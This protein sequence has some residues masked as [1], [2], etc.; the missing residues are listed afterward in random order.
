MAEEIFEQPT[1]L[2]EL[3]RRLASPEDE[4]VSLRD[5]YISSANIRAFST[6]TGGIVDINEE[7]DDSEFMTDTLQRLDDKAN[8]ARVANIHQ[9]FGDEAILPTPPTVQPPAT[10]LE[11]E[12]LPEIGPDERPGFIQSLKENVFSFFSGVGEAELQRQE[13]LQV[14]AEVAVPAVAG[15]VQDVVFEG[16][17]LL[18]D[19]FNALNSALGGS[20]DAFAVGEALDKGTNYLGIQVPPAKT[21][22]Q[23]VIRG[24]TKIGLEI[25]VISATTGGLGTGSASTRL[26]G[27]GKFAQMV[28]RMA[29][30][31]TIGAQV[32]ILQDPEQ[33][34]L[35]TMIEKV[36]Q[37]PEQYPEAIRAF[38]TGFESLPQWTQDFFNNFQFDEDDSNIEKRLKSVGEGAVLGFLVDL[39]VE[40]LRGI[41]TGVRA[42]NSARAISAD[43]TAGL[44]ASRLARAGEDVPVSPALTGEAIG[45]EQL[46]LPFRGEQLE[47]P[48]GQEQLALPLREQPTSVVPTP[49]QIDTGEQLDLV[50]QRQV[51]KELTPEDV[52]LDFV[53]KGD[54]ESFDFNKV[55]KDIAR[56]FT[57][58]PE[59]AR[60]ILG[61]ALNVAEEV[62][63]IVPEIGAKLPPIQEAA[64]DIL[65]EGQA[66]GMGNFNLIRSKYSLARKYNIPVDQAEDL[67]ITTSKDLLDSTEFAAS[68]RTSPATVEDVLLEEAINAGG[69]Q[70]RGADRVAV[71]ERI[72]QLYNLTDREA[73][74]KIVEFNDTLKGLKD[75]K[76][77]LDDVFPKKP[78]EV[79]P[80]AP[81][82]GEQLELPVNAQQRLDLNVRPRDVDTPTAKPE[83]T[84]AIN[85]LADDTVKE[86]VENTPGITKVVSQKVL[87]E[88]I[89]DML[90]GTV[91]GTAV[92]T[93]TAD[94]NPLL[95][96]FTGA[97]IGAGGAVALGR[98]LRPL[99][100]RKATQ[101]R[102]VGLSIQDG[103]SEGAKTSRLKGFAGDPARVD[104]LLGQKIAEGGPSALAYSLVKNYK[105]GSAFEDDHIKAIIGEMHNLSS[106][107]DDSL[108]GLND[109]AKSAASEET[110][111]NLH[112]SILETGGLAERFDSV[113]TQVGSESGKALKSFDD[114]TLRGARG[115][116]RRFKN[117]AT[118]NVDEM[119]AQANE[120]IKPKALEFRKPIRVGLAAL[121]VLENAGLSAIL[122][123]PA[124]RIKD[125]L[126]NTAFVK[127]ASELSSITIGAGA[128]FVKHPLNPI[129][130]TQ[131]GVTLSEAMGAWE[132][133]GRGFYSA[134]WMAVDRLLATSDDL[135][136]LALNRQIAV[137]KEI[138]ATQGAEAAEKAA[139]KI[140]EGG[141]VTSPSGTSTLG[142]TGAREEIISKDF[143]EKF[144]FTD[145]AAKIDNSEW[146]KSGLEAIN[147]ILGL[148]FR[149]TAASDAFG[150][151]HARMVAKY[152]YAS[153]DATQ[154][155]ALSKKT[156]KEGSEFYDNAFKDAFRNA[157]TNYG[158]QIEEY[159]RET[160]LLHEL[161][162]RHREG[163]TNNRAI[164][165][166]GL[167]LV[168]SVP[169]LGKTLI[170][171]ARVNV[172]GL[173]ST[174]ELMPIIGLFVNRNYDAL[175]A[176]AFKTGGASVSS[177]AIN[178]AIGRQVVGSAVA[179]GLYAMWS[180]GALTGPPRRSEV[181]RRVESERKDPHQMN[182]FGK[183]LS[184]GHIESLV[185]FIGPM[186]AVFELMEAK[187]DAR[188]PDTEIV[189]DRKVSNAWTEASK[190]IID[191]TLNKASLREIR[192]LFQAVSDP[193]YSESFRTQLGRAVGARLNPTS[194]LQRAVG[195]TVRDN[196]RALDR[197]IGF[198]DGI[199]EEIRITK[200]FEEPIPKRNVFGKVIPGD[201]SPFGELINSAYRDDDP[202]ERGSKVMSI[203][204]LGD[205]TRSSNRESILTAEEKHVL[206]VLHEDGVSP[207]N[208]Y[209]PDQILSF[210]LNAEQQEAWTRIRGEEVKRFGFTF[211]EA[212]TDEIDSESFSFL[213]QE[214]K[215]LRINHIFRRYTEDAKE[216]LL[217]EFP[218]IRRGI[219]VIREQDAIEQNL[220]ERRLP[221][222]G[223]N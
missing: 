167:N 23:A 132:G 120:L 184:Y 200:G 179:V 108:R 92:G 125:L 104:A 126:V 209:P 115:Q 107:L 114:D 160:M 181:D 75:A 33:G 28:G 175:V 21:P 146:A 85:K 93:V 166:P 155:T 88:I 143:L 38:Q 4:S 40:G 87:R 150:S 57:I 130:R 218:D 118:D 7:D 158:K 37:N 5:A 216:L 121:D 173:R 10:P 215:E 1:I 211:T 96:G 6:S 44:D 66:K 103:L 58:P 113:M 101:F 83:V 20:P 176:P 84:P 31:A 203:L 187:K 46:P 45:G 145:A 137:L 63:G 202:D 80:Q 53:M 116:A 205:P 25:A 69:K 129:A 15:A 162:R 135:A 13:A 22:E 128:N 111:S 32:D 48:L 165:A 71:K 41:A 142:T 106:K 9:Q 47:L 141:R 193:S 138:K 68:I 19:S 117:F 159:R 147:G 122:T 54:F 97:L 157:D 139:A 212:L 134:T 185:G 186:V 198:I 43:V 190:R 72:K 124:G 156:G 217:L 214:Q 208:F 2:E 195:S 206:D 51:Q 131:A 183:W 192:G 55:T 59:R 79:A 196:K 36:K 49:G 91:G 170:P 171:F 220:S 149:F 223:T 78:E 98:F 213:S 77:T 161:D 17:K 189:N 26:L 61:E 82:V 76:K 34:N 27:G 90:L 191:A 3:D 89:T 29:E 164:V 74:A 201:S 67:L 222:T 94:E 151:Q 123:S 112:K 60:V 39:G 182:V 81:R 42:L 210:K 8:K 188:I 65:A 180:S 12:L 177:S 152:R 133:W 178:E 99:V 100:K 136:E 168:Q 35:V 127:S 221:S 197:N 174:G 207:S 169:G 24:L 62:K 140:K 50:F 199:V 109:A 154:L 110:L 105:P 204:R 18:D 52:A 119:I 219:E 153:R 172:N 30:S 95:G 144:G 86:V 163:L 16:S 56:L 70:F 11:D 194:G 73:V 102:D 64:I 148:G 14:G